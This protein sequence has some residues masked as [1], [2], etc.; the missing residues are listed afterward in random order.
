MAKTLQQLD[1]N[2]YHHSYY[3]AYIWDGLA[4]WWPSAIPQ[5]TIDDWESKRNIIKNDGKTY[6]CEK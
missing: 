5:N 6:K 3:M 2:R 1:G 4:I